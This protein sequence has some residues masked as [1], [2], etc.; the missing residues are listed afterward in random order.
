MRVDG[1]RLSL[2]CAAFGSPTPNITWSSPAQGISD[3]ELDAATND[4]INI[5]TEEVTDAIGNVYVIS[6]LE[7]CAADSN[8]FTA[9]SCTASNGIE[10][11]EE[12]FGDAS[13]TFGIIPIG[14]YAHHI[15]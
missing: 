15:Y 13:A 12:G 2:S 6:I 10:I 4:A 9:Y 14:M 8:M 1:S 5:Y 3:Y 11:A 7:L